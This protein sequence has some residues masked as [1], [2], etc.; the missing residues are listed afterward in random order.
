MSGGP[1][2]VRSST[3]CLARADDTGSVGSSSSASVR[4][5]DGFARCAALGRDLARTMQVPDGPV[6]VTS[7]LEMQCQILQPDD[8]RLFPRHDFDGVGELAQHPLARHPSRLPLQRL[9]LAVRSD[10]I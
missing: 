4:Y 6:G 9:Q 1:S 2:A 8:E 10:G 3:S 7:A 5:G